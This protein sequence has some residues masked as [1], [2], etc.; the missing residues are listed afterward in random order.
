MEN[1]R[2]LNKTQ[3]FKRWLL[4]GAITGA[5]VTAVI[6]II[7]W[8]LPSGESPLGWIVAIPWFA[9]LTPAWCLYKV[10]GIPWYIGSSGRV[11]AHIFLTMM[12]VNSVVIGLTLAGFSRLLASLRKVKD[13]R[14]GR[15]SKYTL[16]PLIIVLILNCGIGHSHE[17]EVHEEIS[18]SAALS[19]GGLISFIKQQYPEFPD[20]ILLLDPRLFFDTSEFGFVPRI[21]LSWIRL[22]SRKADKPILFKN[23]FYDPTKDPAIGLTDGVNLSGIQ[24]FTW[25]SVRGGG[26]TVGQHNDE[27]W[28][29]ARDYYFTAITLPIKSDR[30]Q[31][32]AHLL[33]GLGHV[34]HL[35][36]DLSQ[37]DHVRNDNHTLLKYIEN[38]GRTHYISHRREWFPLRPRGWLSWRD[39]GFRK[40]E[41][42]WDRNK[43][44]GNAKALRDDA[45]AKPGEQLGL[46]EFSNGNFLGEN[47][48]YKEYPL[49]AKHLFPFP[50]LETSTDFRQKIG[51]STPVLFTLRDDTPKQRHAIEK[52]ADGRM[53]KR[54]SML[55]FYAKMFP[56]KMAPY[57]P[58]SSTINDNDV[59]E[60]YHTILLPKAVEYSAG[61]LDYFFRG[62]LQTAV[63]A[64]ANGGFDLTIK[65][66]SG[67]DFKGGEFRLYWDNSSDNR[68]R[69]LNPGNETAGSFILAWPNA[70]ADNGTVT[71]TFKPPAGVTV[72]KFTLVYRGIIGS[73]GGAPIDPVE[74][75][76]SGQDL[77]IATQTFV[78]PVPP[79]PTPC[80][81]TE[82]DNTVIGTITGTPGGTTT[83]GPFPIMDYKLRFT[84]GHY[85]YLYGTCLYREGVP[86]GCYEIFART[87]LGFSIGSDQ[88]I[89]QTNPNCFDSVGDQI[90]C[91]QSMNW[92]C[93]DAA[94]AYPITGG[95]TVELFHR[96]G[97]M[98][99]VHNWC[100]LTEPSGSGP[101]WAIV[102]TRKLSLSEN[103]RIKNW[104]TFENGRWT[105]SDGSGTPN[106][107]EFSAPAS[108]VQ[109]A[110]NGLPSVQG[111][112]GVTVSGNAD[113]GWVVTW[114]STGAR[115][116]L[117]ARVSTGNIGWEFVI[118]KEVEGGAT[119]AEAQR[120]LLKW[121]CD[122]CLDASGLPEWDGTFPVARFVSF[123]GFY[124]TS[125]PLLRI[126][127]SSEVYAEV[128]YRT[129]VPGSESGC[130]WVLDIRCYSWPF[131]W[132]LWVGTKGTG[133]D[134]AGV[135]TR[136]AEWGGMCNPNSGPETLEIVG[137]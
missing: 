46:A 102:R 4:R 56:R 136:Q 19:S 13:S 62:K 103:V 126:N 96:G 70:L 25:A 125:Q 22:G 73:S 99:M 129:Q 90:A 94:G 107:L 67:Q 98:S 83:V 47:A 121:D 32:T 72:K 11:P 63:G 120:I 12:L 60:E 119:T 41:D 53:V 79:V 15:S 55:N 34:I 100:C 131:E 85:R 33:Y 17:V 40:L 16:F 36:Q 110:L 88:I 69:L 66:V 52:N 81:L 49:S 113:T 116:P 61:V 91:D 57:F 18:E 44:T 54:H 133:T 5:S 87:S 109:T 42:F 65:N 20:A 135:Y 104:S 117:E 108:A 137:Y 28:Q 43:Y 45:D 71:A 68:T 124:R 30:D 64:N 78:L 132:S 84:S 75:D 9:I 31:A 106:P 1:P 127:K 101:T 38:Y 29:N 123:N 59:L 76:A 39:S 7:W 10:L 51:A 114:N 14:K 8:I 86:G 3:P 35:N 26:A 128:Q 21:P 58:V 111:N 37:P 89:T 105:V 134:W 50:S 24:S 27:S 97:Q 112:G 2:V 82:P 74:R 118:T 122:V 130:G 95:E 80:D 92:F 48:L 115:S 93:D 77:A 23:H 6:Q